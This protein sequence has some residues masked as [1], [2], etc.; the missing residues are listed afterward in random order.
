MHL[1]NIKSNLKV[2]FF[3][4]LLLVACKEEGKNSAP[5]A[6]S[7]KKVKIIQPKTIQPFVSSAY[8]L[9]ATADTLNW[10]KSLEPGDTLRALLFSNRVDET[11]LTR[12]DTL[13]FPD[14]IYPNLDAYCP[15][16]NSVEGITSV[17]KL[18]VVSYF[19]Q[20]FAVYENGKRIRFGPVSMGK[21]ST[22]TPKGLFFTNWKS[23]KSYSTVDS[24]WILPWSFN[25]AN[26]EGVSLHE[27]AL[28]G[29]PASH[30]CVRLIQSDAYWFYYWADQWKLTAQGQIAAYGTPILIF[31]DY[32]FEGR[33]PWL[34]LAKNKELLQ[35]SEKDLMNEIKPYLPLILERQSTRDS[36]IQSEKV[37]FTSDL[38]GK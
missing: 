15:F 36:L 10:L 29:Y 11:H 37:E 8:H 14:S 30:A 23:K 20:I 27:Y 19:A 35:L 28:P 24:T 7:D 4:L 34:N 21:E 5:S 3:V 13:V 2:V 12:L 6:I 33:K 32:P 1:E 22:P 17:K 31:G 16:P 9:L 26:F 25:F 38:I 18:I